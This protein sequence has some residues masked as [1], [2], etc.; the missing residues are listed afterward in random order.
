MTFTWRTLIGSA[1]TVAC[2]LLV[3]SS[4]AQAPFRIGDRAWTSQQAF[5]ESGARC[6]TA[7][8]DPTTAAGLA[9]LLQNGFDRHSN[10]VTLATG[11]TIDVYFHV[12]NR[13]TG[14][15]NGDVPD[16]QIFNQISV[17]NQAF[18]PSGW[19]FNLV[20]VTRTTNTSWFG[21]TPGSVA[22]AQAKAA[23]RQGT[24]D[25]LNFYTAN[26]SGGLLG[27]ATFPWTYQ[28]SPQQDG[29]VVLY[30]SLP[31]GSAVPYDQG[32]TGTHE[33]GHWMG[34]LHTFQ[35]GCSR[36]NDRLTDTP[37]ERSPASGCPVGRNTCAQ[38][39]DDPIHNFMDY[40]D[41]A[42]MFE[43]TLKG[44]ARMNAAFTMFREGK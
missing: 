34:L 6:A 2:A 43:F 30:S 40:S 19:A 38:A 32:D 26:P 21:M 24:A 9:Q 18:A 23:L 7:T 22:E 29:V 33:V 11:G 44:T 39:G 37:A 10:D 1:L 41:D 15:A 3:Q 35:G 20:A 14:I 42:C 4:Q 12:I 13:G 25:D 27:W 16:Q 31:G 17:L 28:N 8:V 5:L 36:A